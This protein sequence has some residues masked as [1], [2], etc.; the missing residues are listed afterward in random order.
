MTPDE[1]IH[2]SI[3]SLLVLLQSAERLMNLTMTWVLRDTAI[4]TI[5]DIMRLEKENRKK[6][7]GQFF[8]KLRQSFHVNAKFDALLTDFLNDRNLFVHSLITKFDLGTETGR[9]T[10][11]EFIAKLSSE[12]T[13]VLKIFSAFVQRWITATGGEPALRDSSASFYASDFYQSLEAD[14]LPYVDVLVRPKDA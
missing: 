13:L 10:A 14:I 3:G 6:T 11:H 1:E 9:I 8:S 7:L 4:R 12:A 2:C 5:E